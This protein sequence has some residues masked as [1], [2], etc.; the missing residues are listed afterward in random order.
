[1]FGLGV[2]FLGEPP[3]IELSYQLS[4]P[5]HTPVPFGRFD[6]SLAGGRLVSIPDYLAHCH[7]AACPKSSASKTL[8]LGARALRTADLRAKIPDFGG[9][10]SSR[11]LI[12]VDGSL[13]VRR[14][15][16]GKFESTNL[17]RDN[18]GREVGHKSWLNNYFRMR[19]RI[20][21]SR[22]ENPGLQSL[23]ASFGIQHLVVI[24]IM[25]VTIR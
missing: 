14:E 22:R 13:H 16:P 6:I 1:M 9:S 11:I 17:G 18:L 3:A 4:Y 15:F 21:E 7:V 19:V 12:L 8:A 5:G 24:I 25:I 23:T 20:P 10:D 2:P